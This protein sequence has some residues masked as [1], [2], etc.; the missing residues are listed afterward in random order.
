MDFLAKF[1][2]GELSKNKH[3]KRVPKNKALQ[4][5]KVDCMNY[6]NQLY[7]HCNFYWHKNTSEHN[8]NLCNV[9]NLGVP[10]SSAI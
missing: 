1:L 10:T 9:L 4:Y 8:R 7:N 5:K 3:T 6:S 2:E